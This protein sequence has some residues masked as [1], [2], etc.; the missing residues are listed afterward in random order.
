[1]NVQE[2]I[3]KEINYFLQSLLFIEFTL[4]KPTEICHSDSISLTLKFT[5]WCCTNQ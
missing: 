5:Y 2:I 1:M 3:Q 4:C